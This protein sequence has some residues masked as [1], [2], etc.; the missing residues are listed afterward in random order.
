MECSC[1]TG[2][3][4][5]QLVI[6]H[7]DSEVVLS[8]SSAHHHTGTPRRHTGNGTGELREELWY[9]DATRTAMVPP[10]RKART[11]CVAALLR[12]SLS[13]DHRNASSH[14]HKVTPE[15]TSERT[16][17][18][19]TTVLASEARRVVL[20]YTLLHGTEPL[21]AKCLHRHGW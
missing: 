21:H 4:T 17:G 14:A 20:W 12:W 13:S 3:H 8:Q 1:G 2:L 18:T 19:T 6:F 11:A 15:V 7:C 16:S 10:A 9:S 5:Q